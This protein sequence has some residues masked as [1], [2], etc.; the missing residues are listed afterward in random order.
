MKKILVVLMVIVLTFAMAACGG[1]KDAA[2]D[3]EKYDMA[4]GTVRSTEGFSFTGDYN[5]SY[6]EGDGYEYSEEPAEAA[7][8]TELGLPSSIDKSKVKLIYN[9]S[10][11]VQT[12][13]FDEAVKGLTELVNKFD[14][15]FESISSDNGSYYDNDE[16]RYGTYTARIPSEKYQQFLDSISEGLHVVNMYQNVQDIGQMYFETESRIETLKN[17]HDRLEELLSQAT[18]M[19]DIIELESALS[20]T[21]YELQQYNTDLLRYDSL[22]GYSTVTVSI[23]KVSQF[24]QGI[25]EELTFGQRLMRS[26]TNGAENFGIGLEDLVNWLGYHLIQIV[27]LIILIAI[28]VKAKV[29]S[30]IRGLFSRKPQKY[31]IE[32]GPE[33]QNTVEE[34]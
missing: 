27:V 3:E 30:R 2:T 1:S 34:K 16:Y 5:S 6:D 12:L 23:E 4:D 26:I 13:N 14:G 7:G 8:S 21:E 11:Y 17:K 15:Y 25:E 20:D 18:K 31:V 32:K 19:K 28:V 22:I 10:L 33:P 9:A 24:D 29:F